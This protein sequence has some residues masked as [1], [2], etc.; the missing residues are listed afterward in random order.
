MDKFALWFQQ[1]NHDPVFMIIV[2]GSVCLIMYGYG[3]Y[4]EKELLKGKSEEEKKD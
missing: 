2:F 4:K 3:R 1:Y